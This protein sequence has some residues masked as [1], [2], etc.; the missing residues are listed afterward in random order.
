MECQQLGD[1]WEL[2]LHLKKEASCYI[3]TDGGWETGESPVESATT[4]RCVTAAPGMKDDAMSWKGG[5][6]AGT[7]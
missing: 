6:E 5:T 3:K 7:G 2:L 4:I 1:E